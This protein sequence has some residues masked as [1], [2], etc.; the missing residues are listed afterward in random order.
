MSDIVWVLSC[1]KHGI[2]ERG[3][4][5]SELNR[6]YKKHVKQDRCLEVKEVYPVQMDQRFTI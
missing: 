1:E 3:I 5:K 2:Y 4:K 6:L